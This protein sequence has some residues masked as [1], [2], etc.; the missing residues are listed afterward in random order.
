MGA[1]PQTS[2]WQT[3]KDFPFFLNPP[4]S[5]WYGL[6]PPALPKNNIQWL[7]RKWKKGITTDED[8]ARTGCFKKEKGSFLTVLRSWRIAERRQAMRAIWLL[9]QATC[10][11]RF[12]FCDLYKSKRLRAQNVRSVCEC[13]MSLCYR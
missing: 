6:C 1:K 7:M 9:C 8:R 5:S 12:S 4:F 3:R 2:D 11:H 10:S 13:A